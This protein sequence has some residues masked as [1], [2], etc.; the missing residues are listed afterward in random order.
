MKPLE[1]QSLLSG[2]FLTFIE[3]SSLRV[4]WSGE[5][6]FVPIPLEA[7]VVQMVASQPDPWKRL[8][9]EPCSN[10]DSGRV[11]TKCEMWTEGQGA[12][13]LGAPDTPGNQT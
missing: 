7:R 6:V 2:G 3:T 4:F 10:G 1:T 5:R 12:P 8:C 9:P 13:P 11:L